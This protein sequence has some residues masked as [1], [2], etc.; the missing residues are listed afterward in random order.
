M[1][2]KSWYL[3]KTGVLSSASSLSSRPDVI[4]SLFVRHI[5]LF[6]VLTIRCNLQLIWRLTH[7]HDLFSTYKATMLPWLRNARKSGIEP[8]PGTAAAM[9]Q[10]QG[11]AVGSSYSNRTSTLT[12]NPIKGLGWAGGFALPVCKFARFYNIVVSI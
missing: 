6:W 9:A 5:T 1:L 3:K 2:K 4:L 8:C 10:Q 12:R 7:Q 11:S